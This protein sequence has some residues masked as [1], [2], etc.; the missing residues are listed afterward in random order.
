MRPAGGPV[1]LHQH[2]GLKDITFPSNKY[3]IHHSRR[4]HV[5]MSRFASEH[6]AREG[7]DAHLKSLR[8]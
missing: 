1:T 7:V 2:F 3:Q 4:A 6:S 8:R 5:N